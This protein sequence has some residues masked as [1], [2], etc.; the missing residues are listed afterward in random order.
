M[1][2]LNNNNINRRAFD[3]N[4]NVAIMSSNHRKRRG[5]LPKES[6]KI[7]RMWLYEHRYNAYPSDQEKQYLSQMANLSVL[8]VCNW[9]INARRR[10]LPDIIRKEG[11]DPLKYTITRKS[12]NKRQN[13]HGSQNHISSRTV[14][15]YG[16]GCIIDNQRCTTNDV[17]D[18][19]DDDGFSSND[20][21]EDIDSSADSDNGSTT[22]TANSN[23]SAYSRPLSCSSFNDSPLKLTK[24]W[25]KNHE[26]EQ[27]LQQAEFNLIVNDNNKSNGKTK[28]AILDIDH[29][30]SPFVQYHHRHHH[31]YNSYRVSNTTTSIVNWINQTTGNS[32]AAAAAATMMQLS[33]SS[34]N[35]SNE[36]YSPDL[37][38]LNDH[39]LSSPSTTLSS[40]SS[41]IN[42]DDHIE[43]QSISSLSSTSSSVAGSPSSFN[44]LY[45]LA[46][47]A[48]ERLSSHSNNS[49]DD[50]HHQ[51]STI[52]ND[53]SN[54]NL[55]LAIKT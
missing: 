43:Q 32:A 16:F 5:N 44:Y 30:G 33:S 39:S 13:N 53:E 4:I 24:R 29:S 12:S 41:S 54:N 31:H 25:R 7:L 23:T 48:V 20:S 45:L 42:G 50:D 6:V 22:S 2:L 17:D 52:K 15:Q 14:S 10:I 38:S 3:S 18:D 11:N 28:R 1:K 37:S 36:S 27:Q 26:E 47:A 55:K 49:N 8:Q 46:S 35:C 9:F 51:S 34:S 19:E 21:S 40:L